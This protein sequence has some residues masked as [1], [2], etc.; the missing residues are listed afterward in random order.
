MMYLYYSITWGYVLLCG[1]C[2]IRLARDGM[3]DVK[4]TNGFCCKIEKDLPCSC[5]S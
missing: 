2:V 4:H 1:N 3:G 5:C